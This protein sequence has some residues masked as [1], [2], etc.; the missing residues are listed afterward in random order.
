M[1]GLTVFRFPLPAQA[2]KVE[3]HV[4]RIFGSD[5][6]RLDIYRKEIIVNDD[7]GPNVRDA[8]VHVMDA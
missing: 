1:R 6:G 3:D 7:L 8:P 5:W 4:V 2:S